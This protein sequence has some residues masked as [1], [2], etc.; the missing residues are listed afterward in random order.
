MSR[1]PER[2]VRVVSPCA[3]VP[4]RSYPEVVVEPPAAVR[5]ASTRQRGQPGEARRRSPPLPERRR[6]F[7]TVRGPGDQAGGDFTVSK[8]HSTDHPNGLA[9]SDTDRGYLRGGASSHPGGCGSDGAP[10]WSVA[11][12]GDCSQPS[13]AQ[14]LPP[15]TVPAAR[16]RHAF[17][18]LALS[19]SARREPMPGTSHPP[20][21]ANTAAARGPPQR[22]AAAC[23]RPCPSGHV[24]ARAPL[25]SRTSVIWPLRFG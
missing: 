5:L 14:T 21:T 16:L 6:G 12:E 24:P 19:S 2:R 15:A 9:H 11:P 23:L 10:S 18:T 22:A 25:E 3:A 4:S 1:S 13:F 17:G 20:R 7:V 8:I